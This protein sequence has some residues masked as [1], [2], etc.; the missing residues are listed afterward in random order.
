MLFY[1]FFKTLIGKEVTIYLKND[2]ELTGTLASV[3]PF[4]NLKL[5]TPR[6]E[7]PS[8]HPHLLALAQAFVRGSVIRYVAVPEKAVDTELLQDAARR[9]AMHANKVAL[10]CAS[11]TK[12]ARRE[13]GHG[14]AA[15]GEPDEEAGA[16]EVGDE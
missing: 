1:S 8:E 14:E 7:D 13:D 9:E 5:T 6:P 10:A 11:G 15:A 16:E 12:K 2:V 3:D 4:L